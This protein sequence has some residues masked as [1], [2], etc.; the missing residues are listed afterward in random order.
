MRIFSKNLFKHLE[1]LRYPNIFHSLYKCIHIMRVID[2]SNMGLYSRYT[3]CYFLTRII[4]Y[5]KQH[6]SKRMTSPP[7]Y[8]FFHILLVNPY[9]HFNSL[10]VEGISFQFISGIYEVS[11][12]PFSSRYSF[13]ISFVSSR[14]LILFLFMIVNKN[15]VTIWVSVSTNIISFDEL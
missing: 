7:N 3:E 12:Q 2:S 11:S 8:T 5:I 10:A 6:I 1:I 15:L 14:I 13:V 4:N 9:P